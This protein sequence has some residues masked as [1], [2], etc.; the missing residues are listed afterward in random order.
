MLHCL[1][2]SPASSCKLS[3]FFFLRFYLFIH[4]THRERGRDNRQRE[5]QAPCRGLDTG[6][7]PGSPGSRPGPKADAQPLSP[8]GVPAASFLNLT[9]HIFLKSSPRIQ[10]YIQGLRFARTSLLASHPPEY[11]QPDSRPGCPRCS[12]V[13]QAFPPPT[14]EAT[15]APRVLPLH[16][17]PQASL[18]A[19]RRF[20]SWPRPVRH[21]A[22]LPHAR[23]RPAR[24]LG[25]RRILG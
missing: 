24:C 18:G 11:P 8:Q 15:W 3:F 12:S 16:P 2:S 4:E 10:R 23:P 17:V 20:S 1:S 22:S 14:H 5:K 19:A 21:A 9:S 13:G 25:R 7:E 6:L